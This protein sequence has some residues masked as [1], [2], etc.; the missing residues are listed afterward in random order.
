MWTLLGAMLACNWTSSIN[1]RRYP[2]SSLPGANHAQHAVVAFQC[3]TPNTSGNPSGC[4]VAMP[5]ALAAAV[6]PMNVSNS[7]GVWR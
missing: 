4:T 3:G 6:M 7:A 5:F 2:E 1:C